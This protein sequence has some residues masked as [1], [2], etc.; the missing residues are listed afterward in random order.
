[1]VQSTGEQSAS[2]EENVVLS[3][4]IHSPDIVASDGSRVDEDRLLVLHGHLNILQ[5][6]GLSVH[7]DQEFSPLHP[8]YCSASAP[9]SLC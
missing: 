7:R 5:V 4:E 1:M 2:C 6:H 9:G 3:D 8:N